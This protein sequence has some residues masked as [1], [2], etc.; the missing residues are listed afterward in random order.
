MS[1]TG[2]R[3]GAL[4]VAAVL[5]GAAAVGIGAVV[6]DDE[7]QT[8]TSTVAASPNAAP[9]SFA[10]STGDARS[11]QEIYETAGPG[12]VQVTSTS[13]S[14]QDPFFGGQPAQAQGSGFVIDTAG[15]I[16]T[17]FHVVE[18]A[19][20]V[21]VNF[22]GEDAIDAEIV[23]VDPSTDIALLKIDSQARALNPIDLGNSDVVRV[24]DSVVAIGNP[25]GLERTV[26]A[27]IVSAVQRD[28]EAPNGYTIPKAIQTDAPINSGN[29]GGP[30]LDTR[31][32]VIGVNSQIRTDGSGGGNLGIGFA[33]PINTVK[34][35]VDEIIRTG[36]VD[37]AYM[38]ISMQAVDETVAEAMRLPVDEGLMITQVQPGSPAAEAGLRGGNRSVVIDGQTYVVGGDIITRADGREVTS[39]DDLQSIVMAKEPGDSLTLE[40]H[41]GDAE[42]TVSVTLGRQPNQTAG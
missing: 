14:S 15:H 8:V 30:L 6:Q 12:V 28:I 40:I 4:L 9:P 36:K 21:Q 5:G 17:N 37:H 38:G 41:R 16:V 34:Q 1:S 3:L 13:V 42:R 11:V 19:T 35:V 32:E 26:T 2:S 33:V 22:S 18:N 20:E 25:F 7:P 10:E 39:P 31:G 23:G 27:G 24:G 29:S